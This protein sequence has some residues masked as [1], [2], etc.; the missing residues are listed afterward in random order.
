MLIIDWDSYTKTKGITKRHY[1]NIKT[2]QKQVGTNEKVAERIF[3]CKQRLEIIEDDKLANWL[4]FSPFGRDTE[5]RFAKVSWSRGERGEWVNSIASYKHS[6][7]I[8]F[9]GFSKTNTDW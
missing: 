1:L 9:G 2:F 7:W 5:N 8:A 6:I 4:E 3:I